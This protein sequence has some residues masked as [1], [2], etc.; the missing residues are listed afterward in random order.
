MGVRHSHGTL[1]LASCYTSYN[2]APFVNHWYRNFQRAKHFTKKQLGLC[3]AVRGF[4]K[5]QT[6]ALQQ[7]HSISPALLVF[8]QTQKPRLQQKQKIR[9]AQ[10]FSSCTKYH[11]SV[12]NHIS[13]RSNM[14]TNIVNQTT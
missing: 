6:T 4:N 10:L 3:L 9:L 7:K 5:I 1:G 13:L 8:K 2:A 11:T 12:A 14:N